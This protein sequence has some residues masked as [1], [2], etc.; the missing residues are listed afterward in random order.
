MF[1]QTN[2]R[3]RNIHDKTLA[4]NFFSVGDSTAIESTDGNANYKYT[5]EKIDCNFTVI[6]S[7]SI[8]NILCWW[9]R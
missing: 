4:C 7:V 8:I 3:M 9:G 1:F 2:T 6:S 5:D